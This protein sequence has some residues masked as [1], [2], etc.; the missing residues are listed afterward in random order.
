MFRI[1]KRSIYFFL[2]LNI[3]WKAVVPGTIFYKVQSITNTL[4]FASKYRKFD[5]S[6][7]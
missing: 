7:T 3:A 4:K 5:D 2:F 6:D 1:L